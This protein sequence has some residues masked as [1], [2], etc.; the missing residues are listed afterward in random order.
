MAISDH[1]SLDLEL[2]KAQFNGLMRQLKKCLRKECFKIDAR[3]IDF[4]PIQQK[5]RKI[6]VKITF[7]SEMSL[8]LKSY[9]ID[10][11]ILS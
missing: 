5:R 11:I 6:G 3:L 10:F 8:L 7:F 2:N 9:S 4:H 1:L